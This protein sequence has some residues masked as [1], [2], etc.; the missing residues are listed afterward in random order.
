MNIICQQCKERND[1]DTICYK[2]YY[3]TN[4][5]DLRGLPCERF[6]TLKKLQDEGREYCP[7]SKKKVFIAEDNIDLADAMKTFFEAKGFDVT[8]AHSKPEAL[9]LIPKLS[10]QGYKVAVLDGDLGSG[11][12]G[13]RDGKVVSYALRRAIEDIVIIA[14]SGM[15]GVIDWADYKMDKFSTS[16]KDLLIKVNEI[17]EGKG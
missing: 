4:G 10:E 8:V 11:D 13:T 5:K 6:A 16:P 15:I 7:P 14:H 1:D 3:Q 12:E 9:S 17:L 2:G